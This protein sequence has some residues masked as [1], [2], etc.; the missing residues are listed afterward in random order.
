MNQR[1][2]LDMIELEFGRRGVPADVQA[3]V[4]D[5]LRIAAMRIAAEA[6]AEQRAAARHASIVGA[7][8]TRGKTHF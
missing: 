5:A 3:R 1:R 8:I 6:D 4:K 7:S 2:V